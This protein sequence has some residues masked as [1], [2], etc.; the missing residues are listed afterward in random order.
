MTGANPRGGGGGQKKG[1]LLW[2]NW[3][4]ADAADTLQDY[5]SHQRSSSA[6]FGQCHSAIDPVHVRFVCTP[7]L[8]L[9]LRGIAW[10]AAT[11]AQLHWLVWTPSLTDFDVKSVSSS[12]AGTL[13]HRENLTSR[14]AKLLAWSTYMS[15]C[16]YSCAVC[17]RQTNSNPMWL[18]L[19]CSR[20]KLTYVPAVKN[21]VSAG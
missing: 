20:G 17:L 8:I 21:V 3:V 6:V 16:W 13:S 11:P 5:G 1:V 7:I 18:L 10:P 9:P 12:S 15:S 4:S 19:R 14:L 2:L